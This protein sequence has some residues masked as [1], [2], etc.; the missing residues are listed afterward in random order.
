MWVNCLRKVTR[1]NEEK[2]HHGG[3]EVTERWKNNLFLRV[4]R[5]SV[6]PISFSAFPMSSVFSVSLWFLSFN[7]MHPFVQDKQCPWTGPSGAAL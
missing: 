4:L 6:V 5:V 2:Y 7:L 1:R 3:T